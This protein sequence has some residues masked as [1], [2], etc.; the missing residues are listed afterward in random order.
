[1]LVPTAPKPAPGQPW[2][3]ADTPATPHES[4]LVLSCPFPVHPITIDERSIELD[5]SYQ[6]SVWLSMCRTSSWLSGNLWRA[7]PQHGWFSNVA[8]VMVMHND[9][10]PSPQ[11]SVHR[12]PCLTRAMAPTAQSNTTAIPL[13]DRCCPRNRG[14]KYK[15]PKGFREPLGSL[16]GEPG[17]M[18]RST[19]R[20]PQLSELDNTR[21]RGSLR[22][23][24][25]GLFLAR[26]AGLEPTT[27]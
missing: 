19:P 17:G 9:Q 7:R 18:L 4:D 2:H 6:V 8:K 11:S 5:P 3:L 12:K 23:N 25:R 1:M 13:T 16:F 14:G 24:P 21:P 26:P 27:F 15:T 22:G 20:N 10:R